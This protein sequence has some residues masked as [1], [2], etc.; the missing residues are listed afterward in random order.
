MPKG[1]VHQK[2]R[3]TRHQLRW[4]IEPHL[5]K[6]NTHTPKIEHTPSQTTETQN[7]THTT[8]TRTPAQY[9]NEGDPV[10][11]YIWNTLKYFNTFTPG[12]L[13]KFFLTKLRK[14]SSLYKAHTILIKAKKSAKNK[15][16][17]PPFFE[18]L[19][20]FNSF[21][22]K[23]FFTK[24]VELIR[25]NLSYIYLY[26]HL[27]FI[28]RAFSTWAIRLGGLGNHPLR[29]RRKI[30]CIVLY[31]IFYFNKYVIQNPVFFCV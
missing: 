21:E 14:R 1:W 11:S 7:E 26:T 20:W 8:D 16:N 12:A 29:Y 28:C 17:C 4:G 3:A 31:C 19:L 24:H 2:P 6:I 15:R 30:N 22:W 13:R 10:L 18:N 27:Y 9:T 25:R 23:A 5:A